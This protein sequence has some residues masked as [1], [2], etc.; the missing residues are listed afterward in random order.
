MKVDL[1]LISDHWDHNCEITL[2]DGTSKKVFADWLHNN[3]L[4]YWKGWNCDA[5]VTRIS[6]TEN[7][8]VFSAR[9]NNDYLGNLNTEWNLLENSICKQ[10]RCTLC[11]DDLMLKKYKNND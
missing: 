5:G 10:D 9:C 1:T 6:I 8:D 7:L 11:T 3:N 2:D 4:D